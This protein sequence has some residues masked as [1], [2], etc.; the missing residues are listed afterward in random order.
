[1]LKKV[2]L[3]LLAA[4]LC[5]TAPTLAQPGTTHRTYTNGDDWSSRLGEA[6]ECLQKGE[7]RKGRTIADS[8]LQQVSDQVING[9]GTPRLLGLALLLRS[10]AEAGLGHDRN[11]S[12]DLHASQAFSPDASNVDLSVYGAAGLLLE[13]YR[14]GTADGASLEPVRT[15]TPA[16]TPAKRIKSKSLHHPRGARNGCVQGPAIV[17]AIVGIDGLLHNPQISSQKI[18]S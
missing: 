13:R 5:T 11:A 6:D 3:S 2:L 1:M 4:I 14:N 9:E 12:W 18:H 17:N 10:I 8:V 15:I 7:W 16:L